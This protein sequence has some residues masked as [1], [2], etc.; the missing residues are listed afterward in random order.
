[1]SCTFILYS[2]I[3]SS[4]LNVLSDIS[5]DH[6][7][8]RHTWR[9]QWCESWH[10]CR[11]GQAP[12]GLN[13]HINGSS[14][15][16]HT[17]ISRTAAN[18][19]VTHQRHAFVRPWEYPLRCARGW[20]AEG[21][22]FVSIRLS[23][24]TH[25]GPACSLVPRR[26]SRKHTRF[27]LVVGLCRMAFGLNF[28]G[29]SVSEM[30]TFYPG[31][32]WPAACSDMNNHDCAQ[33]SSRG[34][35][36]NTFILFR[37]FKMAL[38]QVVECRMI[39]KKLVFMVCKQ[40]HTHIFTVYKV[41]SIQ[42]LVYHSCYAHQSPRVVQFCAQ[43]V[44]NFYSDVWNWNIEEI[45]WTPVPSFSVAHHDAALKSRSDAQRRRK[46][47]T[48]SKAQL[49]ELER[50]FSVTHY[51]DVKMKESLASRTGLPES[52][53]QVRRLRHRRPPNFGLCADGSKRVTAVYFCQQVWFQNRR[54]RYFKSKKPSR[55]VSKPSADCLHSQFSYTP[56]STPQF[57]GLVPCFL[58]APSLPSPPGYPAPSLPQST[59]LSAILESPAVSLA[60]PT[61]PFAADQATAHSPHDGGPPGFSQDLYYPT[62]DFTDYCHDVFQH[63][64][65]SGW[66]LS[67]EFEAF[68][69][70]TLGSEPAGSRCAAVAHSEAKER[71][72]SPP[73]R[74]HSSGHDECTED[75]SDLC[76][77][78]LG[79]FSL[80]DLDISAAMLDY[81]L[82]WLIKEQYGLEIHFLF[83]WCFI[84]KDKES[85]GRQVGRQSS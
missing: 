59:R 1:M 29:A 36:L 52:K 17:P 50:A 66:G 42:P 44:L 4:N 81:L 21:G 5:K 80:S 39:L 74:Q 37:L 65:L 58:P 23:I 30:N 11:S 71:V 28:T 56:A 69:G 35:W 6:F 2:S 33:D 70:D 7:R 78:D 10:F 51:P 20:G 61:S 53:I 57:A 75:L 64:E 55:E 76:A 43:S 48:F 63:S 8:C 49:S 45:C 41:Y 60:E 27:C 19:C 14:G 13:G 34:E 47:T 77:Q 9:S 84:L 38:A 62:P 18:R 40:N 46:R 12:S 24:K 22:L 73:D 3:F 68:F 15:I 83:C 67:Q 79:D 25:W 85:Q 16:K 31:Y 26:V 32:Y 54:A 82:G 72:Q